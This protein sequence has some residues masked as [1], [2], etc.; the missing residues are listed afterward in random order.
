[1]L[2]GTYNPDPTIAGASIDENNV[3][4]E[5]PRGMM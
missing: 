5:D 4:Q 3:I 1:M 2:N